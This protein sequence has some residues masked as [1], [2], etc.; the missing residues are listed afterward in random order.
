M[1]TPVQIDQ[2]VFNA[3][4]DDIVSKFDTTASA[5]DPWIAKNL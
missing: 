1:E 2:N 5:M 3:F 4:L